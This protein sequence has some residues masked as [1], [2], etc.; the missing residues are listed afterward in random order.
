MRRIPIQGVSCAALMI[1][2]AI[3][4]MLSAILVP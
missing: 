3:F 2:L 4:F 1:V